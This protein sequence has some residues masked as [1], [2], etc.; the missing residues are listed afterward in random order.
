MRVVGEEGVGMG[1]EE[2]FRQGG[3]RVKK[4]LGGSL[5][6]RMVRLKNPICVFGVG[7]QDVVPFDLQVP[8]RFFEEWGSGEVG[9]V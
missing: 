1:N 3:G 8:W 9:D 6:W 4:G 5:T 7:D 2:G